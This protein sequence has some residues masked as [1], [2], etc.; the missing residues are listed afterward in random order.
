MEKREGFRNGLGVGLFLCAIMVVY[1]L[2]TSQYLNSKTKVIPCV[3]KELY[4]TIDD[5]TANYQGEAVV[6]ATD[7][8]TTVIQM[9]DK[10]YVASTKNVVYE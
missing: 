8:T 9:G 5:G 3:G 7:E 10:V 2:V 4:V 1:M 6:I